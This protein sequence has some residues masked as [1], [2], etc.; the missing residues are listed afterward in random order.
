M[1]TDTNHQKDTSTTDFAQCL[2]RKDTP[3]TP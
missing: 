2:N 3:C 1:S